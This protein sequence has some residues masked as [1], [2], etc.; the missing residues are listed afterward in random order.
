MS[1]E[2]RTQKGV[3][4]FLKSK[5]IKAVHL[6]TFSDGFLPWTHRSNTYDPEIEFTD[7]SALTFF[8]HECVEGSAVTYGI[9]ITYH[10]P[11][12]EEQ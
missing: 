10:P 9:D 11:I 8:V 6:N 1:I 2:I 12:K 7:G 3:A 4:R 5:R